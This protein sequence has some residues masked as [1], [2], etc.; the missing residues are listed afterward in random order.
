[1][2]IFMVLIVK[3]IKYSMYKKFLFISVSVFFA[4]ILVWAAHI[5]LDFP[6]INIIKYEDL[7]NYYNK[8]TKYSLI[9]IIVFI[10]SITIYFKENS[11]KNFLDIKLPSYNANSF[12]FTVL[13]VINRIILFISIYFLVEFICF[14]Y[15]YYIPSELG[16]LC[17]KTVDVVINNIEENKYMDKA[18][19]YMNSVSN[20]TIS[21]VEKNFVNGDNLNLSQEY[22]DE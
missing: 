21:P 15:I 4:I 8:I 5:I 14:L 9:F 6:K 3:N 12:I 2:T 16:P 22:Y 18:V 11:V 19:K 20:V 13:L 7:F 1:M 10:V 17:D